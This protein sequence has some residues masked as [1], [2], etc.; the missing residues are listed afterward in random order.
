MRTLFFTARLKLP[1]R[2]FPM[3]SLFMEP[4]GAYAMNISYGHNIVNN[5]TEDRFHLIVAR[6]DSIE[7]WKA[8]I[9][10]AANNAGVTGHYELH[11]IAV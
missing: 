3:E 4:G 10:N 8:L 6:H 11:K 9:N 2:V 5:S 1:G 7:D